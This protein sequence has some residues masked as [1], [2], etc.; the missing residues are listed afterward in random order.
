M[1]GVPLRSLLNHQDAL[2]VAGSLGMECRAVKSYG[3]RLG[4]YSYIHI[5]IYLHI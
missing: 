3:L 2:W 5:H 1:H 4:I